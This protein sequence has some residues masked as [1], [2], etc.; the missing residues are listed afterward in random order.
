MNT[1]PKLDLSNYERVFTVVDS[2]TQGEFTRIV[3]D[4]MPP[5][6]GNTMTEKRDYLQE[7]CSDLRR[8]LLLEPRGHKDCFGAVITEPCSK[9]ADFGIVFM[10][11]TLFT[12]MCGHGTIGFSTVAVEA[13]LVEVTEP[14]TY[15]TLEAPAG[16]IKVKVKVEHKKA[17]EVTLTNV[18]SFVYKE[19]LTMQAAGREIQYDIVFGGQFFAMIDVEQLGIRDIDNHSV[20]KLI[21]IGYEIIQK[22]KADSSAAVKH[23]ELD[24]T[25]IDAV[26]FYGRPG[27]TDA[28]VRNVVTFG[29]LQADRSPCGTGTSAK[30][31]SLYKNGK[32]K[33]G[34]ELKNESFMGT[35]FKGKIAGTTKVGEYD[36][37]IPTITGSANVTG[38]GT[39]I[40]DQDDPLKYGFT[41]GE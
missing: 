17:V 18:P 22:L 9:E 24:I 20:G 16:L 13:G 34:D 1:T 31:A 8:A 38:V 32:I 36:A 4:G 25:S 21:Q 5:I 2:H 11:S 19:N 26:E 28:D 15:L 30:L 37:V 3:L 12:N 23:P 33:E 6:P 7:H 35:I 41:V 27:R 14:Y 40:I 39:Y 29:H 10:E